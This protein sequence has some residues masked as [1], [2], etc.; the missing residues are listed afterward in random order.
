MAADIGGVSDTNTPYD[1]LFRAAFDEPETARELTL[2]LLPERYASRLA[3]ARVTLEPETL[4]DR[5]ARYRRTDLLLRFTSP[6]TTTTDR[7]TYVY[8]LYEHKSYRDRWVTVQVLHAMATIW[9]RLAGKTG[10]REGEL[11]P[12]ILPVV[13]YHGAEAWNAPLQV[14]D[15]IA[16]GRDS[17]H[18]P[19]Y[20]PIF[21]DLRTV[22]D[23]AITGSLRA[24]LGLVALKHVRL[25]LED[26]T[27]EILTELLHRAHADPTTRHLARVIEQV[28]VIV[29]S[30]EDVKRLMTA[31][32]RLGYYEVEGD[33]M[34]YAQELLAEGRTEGLK[35]GLEQG[36]E[37]GSLQRSREVLIRLVNRKFGL[38]D[39]ERERVMVCDDQNALDA[40]LDE[41]ALA[42]TKAQVLARLP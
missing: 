31:A 1:T 26:A 8:V 33:Y 2:L 16:G 6:G 21:L 40:A 7:T 10:R 20:R 39:A 35:Q 14:A 41:F 38:T 3:S 11:L 34:T 17:P 24:V 18:V 32:S 27:A 22:P 13:L 15:L 23:D 28:Y 37:K 5:K 25:K 19:H 30:A 12:E 9:Q 42:D 4:V 36:M 29:R